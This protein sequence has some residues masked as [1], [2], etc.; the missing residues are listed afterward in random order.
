MKNAAV[1]FIIA[2]ANAVLY[3]GPGVHQQLCAIQPSLLWGERERE[4]EKGGGADRGREQRKRE[5]ESQIFNKAWCGGGGVT[6]PPPP[7]LP[8]VTREKD[9]NTF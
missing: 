2:D 3:G 7:P 4:G 5:G 6:V 1:T 9:Y 8:P